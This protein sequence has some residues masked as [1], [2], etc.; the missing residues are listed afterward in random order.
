MADRFG[1]L[2]QVACTQHGV[3]T[4]ADASRVGV[5]AA[6]LS[7][8][9]R[10]G[11]VVR[12]RAGVFRMAAAPATWEADLLAACLA[13]RGVA[14]H[15]SAARLLGLADPRTRAL[16]VSV[17]RSCGVRPTWARVFRR[18]DFDLIDPIP[19]LGIPVTP[20]ERLLVDLGAVATI[21][22]LEQVFVQAWTSGRTDP[23]R[24]LRS[25]VAHARRGRNGVGKLRAVLDEHLG[26]V[27][28]DSVLEVAF[29]QL[30]RRAGLPEPVAQV[31]LHDEAGFIMRADYAYPEQRVAIEIDSVTHHLHREAFEADR[32]K[33]NRARTAG[34]TII[35]ITH[36]MLREQPAQV[37]LLI[38]RALAA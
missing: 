8:W 29:A 5:A 15:R 24:A 16:D 34:W 36:R 19:V 4:G 20:I 26:V 38:S 33:R 13:T 17:S 11:R 18:T 3:F 30:L 21:D 2:S 32:R 12:L 28:G 1:L 10:R 9:V 7:D 35:E 31:D 37:C 6:T 25:L 23:E 27:G 14:S 22:R